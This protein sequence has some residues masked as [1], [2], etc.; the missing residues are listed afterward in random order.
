MPAS[1][2]ACHVA[3]IIREQLP[4]DH[5]QLHPRESGQMPCRERSGP[6]LSEHLCAS[7]GA[8]CRH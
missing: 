4:T 6:I 5:H 2:V 1:P 8:F 7:V 3:S